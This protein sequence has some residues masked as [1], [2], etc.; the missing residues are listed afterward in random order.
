MFELKM[1]KPNVTDIV[2]SAME[3]GKSR[4]SIRN[5]ERQEDLGRHVADLNAANALGKISHNIARTMKAADR[6]FDE[7]HDHVVKILR[8]FSKCV[9]INEWK[10]VNSVPLEDVF[11]NDY[12]GEHIRNDLDVLLRWIDRIWNYWTYFDDEQ[13]KLLL[14]HIIRGITFAAYMIKKI[15]GKVDFKEFSYSLVAIKFALEARILKDK[16]RIE[17]GIWECVEKHMDYFSQF[18]MELPP[19][20]KE[21]MKKMNEE[22]KRI[23]KE[24]R[25]RLHEIQ[26]ERALEESKKR[27]RNKIRAQRKKHSENQA[28]KKKGPKKGRLKPKKKKKKKNI[29]IKEGESEMAKIIQINKEKEKE[30]DDDDYDDLPPTKIVEIK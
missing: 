12:L 5:N 16:K 15:Y 14:P 8:K 1:N 22:D 27:S 19:T 6:V 7:Y 30:D 13:L 9:T 25:K 29:N 2:R 23:E 17:L 4:R 24:Q 28:Q 20:Y 11:S 18:G 10:V 26:M 21:D 3:Q